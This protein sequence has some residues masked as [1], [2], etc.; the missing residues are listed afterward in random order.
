MSRKISRSTIILAS[1]SPRRHELLK[2]HFNL[3]RFVQAIDESVR[4]GEMPKPY[5]R[6]MALEKWRASQKSWTR[7]AHYPLL[8]ADTTVVCGS[9][10]LGKAASKAE[11]KRI[12]QSLSGRE[13]WVHTCIAIGCSS[14]RRPRIVK[15]VSTRIRFRRISSQEM[16][17]YL[18]SGEWRGKAGAYGIQGMAS[19]FVDAIWGS[20]TSVVGLPVN[21]SLQGVAQ[22]LAHPPA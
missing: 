10:I 6:R 1:A 4:R 12:L 21:E 19:C 17:R 7:S 18:A 20:L 11:A 16:N 22:V 2:D 9:K 8:A 13:H 5:V 3:I 14:E 15:T